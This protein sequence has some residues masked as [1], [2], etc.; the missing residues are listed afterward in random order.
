MSAK[1]IKYY[2]AGASDARNSRNFDDLNNSAFFKMCTWLCREENRDQ[3]HSIYD[4]RKQLSTYLPS[5]MPAY[6]IKHLRRRLNEHF[7]SD[8]IIFEVYGNMNV[9][10]LRHRVSDILNDIYQEAEEDDVFEKIKTY[11][12]AAIIIK[13]EMQRLDESKEFYPTTNEIDFA[14][15]EKNVPTCL[16]ELVNTLFP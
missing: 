15:L 6:S 14:L 13:E 10:T 2:G 4:I 3:Q 1:N 11:K 8:L 12:D 9:V 5:D 7:G 16:F